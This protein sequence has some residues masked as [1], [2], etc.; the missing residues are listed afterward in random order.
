VLEVAGVPAAVHLWFHLGPVATWH[1]T[2]YDQRLAATSAGS[3]IMWWAHERIFAGQV[4]RLVDLMPGHNP[5]KDRL[6]PDRAPILMLEATSRTLV[7]GV[8]FPVAHQA[9]RVGRGLGYR[10]RAH[11]RRPVTPARPGP[12][13][14]RPATPVEVRPGTRG[15]QVEPLEL[16]PGLRRFLAVA[17]GHPSPEAMAERWAE[18]DSWWRVGER[19]RALVRLGPPRPEPGPRPVREIVLL[20][21]AQDDVRE[22]LAGVASAVGEPLVADLAA[23]DDAEDAEDAG[24]FAR[25]YRSVVPWPER[26]GRPGRRP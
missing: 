1:S 10:L 3:I 5:L 9:R 12:R 24:G 20:P 21:G 22:V 6:G 15:P 13:R 8:T 17:G 16:D 23:G 2:A 7:S 25:L 11:R 19:P 14:P 26:A 4:P 18:Q